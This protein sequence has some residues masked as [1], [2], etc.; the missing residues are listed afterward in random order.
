M[1]HFREPITLDLV[2]RSLD[3]VPFS[4]PFVV[5]LPILTP[6][7]TTGSVALE[8]TLETAFVVGMVHIA[9]NAA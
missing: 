3:K 9:Y 5:I 6:L 2:L 4:K 8:C 7:G 1:T